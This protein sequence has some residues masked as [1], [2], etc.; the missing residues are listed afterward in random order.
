MKALI[1]FGCVL[2][3]AVIQTVFRQSGIMLGAIPTVILYGGMIWL[4]TYLCKK[5]DES[6]A[7]SQD[8][9]ESNDE[10]QDEHLDVNRSFETIAADPQV[11]SVFV[12]PV[13]GGIYT[14]QGNKTCSQCSI[15]AIYSGYTDE[16]WSGLK[17]PDKQKIIG[18][19]KN[20]VR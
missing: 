6:K 10:K 2:F 9:S 15:P 4:A 5:Y 16:M 17:G 8:K 14:A 12:C 18:Q 13:C 19:I 3:V 11:D 20:A 7:S 1:W